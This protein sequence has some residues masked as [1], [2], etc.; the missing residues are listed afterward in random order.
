MAPKLILILEF[1]MSF[2]FLIPYSL[3][4]VLCAAGL[5]TQEQGDGY[6]L[7]VNSPHHA[8]HSV[9]NLSFQYSPP[10]F[11]LVCDHC[12]PISQ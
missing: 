5:Q 6:P 4:I 10:P 11:L 2:I 3:L 9:L 8:L 1:I 7:E 12:R